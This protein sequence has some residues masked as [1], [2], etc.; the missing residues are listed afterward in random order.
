[1][2]VFRVMIVCRVMAALMM[3]TAVLPEFLIGVYLR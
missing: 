2:P 3:L 1:M